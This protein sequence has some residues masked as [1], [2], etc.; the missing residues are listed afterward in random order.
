[1]PSQLLIN[2]LFHSIQGE[3][4]RAGLACVFIRLRG[5]HLRCTY[6]DTSYAFAQGKA[7][8]IDDILEKVMAWPTQLVQITGGEP[9][10]QAGV[11]ELMTRLADLGRVVLLETSGACDISSCDE[12]VIRIVDFK[13]PGSGEASRNDWSNVEHLRPSDEVKFVLC[14]RADYQW[15]CSIMQQHDLTGRV[16]AVLF[17]PVHAQKGDEYIDGHEGLCPRDLA[18]WMLEDGID[19]RLQLQ[20]H[21]FIWSPTTRGV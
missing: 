18:Q 4:T 13:T 16:A 17:S 20:L 7:M 8:S 10:L 11:H 1:M 19:A 21:K 9:L 6:C 14:D 12:R 5:C 2:E 15:A 3:S